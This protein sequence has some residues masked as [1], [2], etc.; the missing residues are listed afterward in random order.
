MQIFLEGS[1]RTVLHRFSDDRV[2]IDY[3]GLFAFADLVGEDFQ[4]SGIPARDGDEKR[5]LAA[6]TAPLDGTTTV[7]VIADDPG[8]S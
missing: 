6:L 5:V 4:L 2:L 8:G 1:M 3:D 7:T